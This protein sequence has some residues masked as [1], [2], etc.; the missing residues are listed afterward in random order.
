VNSRIK[1]T[2]LTSRKTFALGVASWG[3]PA[4]GGQLGV[5]SWSWLQSPFFIVCLNQGQFLGAKST[6][7][8]DCVGRSVGRSVRRSVPPLVRPPRCA[9]TWK[10]S[11]VA[12]EIRVE[13]EEEE[14]DYVAILLR[15][16]SFAPRD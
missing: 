6:S 15:R 5:A 9:I 12:I 8:R 14:T 4:E 11:Y 16:D 13:E 7:I 10:T 3:W 1:G 2:M